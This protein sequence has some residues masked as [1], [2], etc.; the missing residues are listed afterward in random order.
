MTISGAPEMDWFYDEIV[1][2]FYD[3]PERAGF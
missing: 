1:A 2:G 3:A